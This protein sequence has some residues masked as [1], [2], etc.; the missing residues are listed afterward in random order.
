M[1]E[2]SWNEDVKTSWN[3]KASYWHTNS[4]DMWEKGS[5]KDIIPFFRKHIPYGV[6]IIDIGCGD[7]YGSKLLMEQGYH[8]IGIDISEEMI[9]LAKEN[10]E[11]IHFITGDVQDLPFRDE[12]FTGVIAINCLEWTKDPFK[13]LYEIH[14]ITKNGGYACI[15][16]LGPTA[17]PRENSYPR[18]IGKNAICNTMMPW[19]FERLA[20]E[21]GWRKIAEKGVYKKGVS[22]KL[23]LGLSTELKQALTFMQLFILQRES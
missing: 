20:R 22:E 18:L 17:K 2:Y 19:E 7:G 4:V 11:N 6:D 13:S 12:S 16:I 1:S 14:R 10:N 15:G 21:N 23:L 5:R 9:R 8:V 3:Q